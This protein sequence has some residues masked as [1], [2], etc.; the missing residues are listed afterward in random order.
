M[1]DE[2]TRAALAGDPGAEA[3][4]YEGY[5]HKWAEVRAVADEVAQALARAG[6]P[7]GAAVAFAPRNRPAAIAA[8]LGLIAARHT[9]CMIYA[10]QSPAGIAR[11]VGRAAVAAVVA[12]A[13]DFT[14]EL[15][16]VAAQNGL[17]AIALDGMSAGL[18]P[19][20]ERAAAA[21]EIP[22]ELQI[23]VHTSGT[24]G[25]PKHVGFSFDTLSS[26]IVN[27]APPPGPDAPPLLLTY[28]LGNI[29][30]VYSTLPPLLHRQRVVLADRFSL[31][32]WRDYIS[33]FRPA[34]TGLPPAGIRMLLDAAVPAE[35]LAGIRYIGT[36]AAPLDPT[37]QRQFEETYNIPIL[38]SY[39]ATEFGGPVAAMTPALWAEFGA[40][41]IGSTGRAMPGAQL[42]V[43]DAGTGEELPAGQEGLLEVVSPRIGPQ[44]IRTTD[45]GLLDADGFLYLRGRAD[46]AIVRGGFK[47]LP[48]AIER[49]LCLH[50]SVA[51]AAVVGI[52]DPRLGQ[53]PAAAVQLKPGHPQPPAEAL[54]GHLRQHVYATH[55]PTA[56]RFVA[57]LPLNPS[58]KP[59]LA[60]VR[61]LFTEG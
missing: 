21:P 39:G 43:I 45:I 42:R 10:F 12:C 13:E 40:A 54:A 5:W 49:A 3:I 26:H 48:E 28:P 6:V 17:A 24:T 27:R 2:Q 19:G 18:V 32:I 61:R 41:K 31:D 57:A 22:E 20:A 56:W 25:A 4:E 9:I 8:E 53:V 55:I 60:A 59:D 16:A 11:D 52:D 44:W 38:L 14:P 50:E 58:A 47:L 29:T 46:G 30:G 37:V 34:F 35:E 7:A 23:R 33:R 1:L 36:G 51:Q 15:L